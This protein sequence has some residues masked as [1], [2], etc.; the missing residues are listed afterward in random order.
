MP[1]I[2][3]EDLINRGKHLMVSISG[4]RG[5]IP[6]GLDPVNIVHF[7][8]AFASITG[9]KIVMGNDARPTGPILRHL[10]IGTLIACGKEI[11]DIGL[12][13]TPTVKAAVQIEN[14]DAGVMISASHNPPEWNAF[15]FMGKG[16]FFFNQEQSA[17]LVQ[18]VKNGANPSVDYTRMGKVLEK[19][20]VQ[21]HIKA[22]LSII[23]NVNEIRSKKYTVV[24]DAVSGAGRIA[25][26]MM[27]EELGCKV[28][29]LYCDPTPDGSFPRP[30]EPTPS[31]LKE[32]G[33][34]V[35]HNKASVGFALDPDAD[36][37]VIGS[38]A[39]GTINE[40]YTVPLAMM[41]LEKKIQSYKNPLIVLNQSTADLT[42]YLA[43]KMGAKVI[44][45]AVGEA[46]VVELMLEKNAVYGGEGNGGVILPD[47]PSFGR[48]TLTGAALILS[49]M[50][51]QNAATIDPLMKQL[52]E[53][54]MKKAKIEMDSVSPATVYSD[55]KKKF[56]DSSED[57]T[58]GLRLV[59]KDGSWIHARPSNTEPIMRII[60]QSPSASRLEEILKMIS[61]SV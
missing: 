53:L 43:N 12:A 4:I 32:F 20:G 11:I 16:G 7:S 24:V 57:T 60:A 27:L 55:I 25:L 33:D 42:E 31:A 1:Q 17:A 19:D 61:V 22:V 13:P 3:R 44:R 18:A 41:G 9:K 26:P 36:R 59:L 29:R 45:S 52:P 6:D 51:S 30:P 56:P 39:T 49:A 37:L 15:K 47:V 38:P 50:A 5:V 8:L 2:N 46:N 23:L 58:D 35:I 34:L 40:E 10:L 54:H 48:D 14:A 28:I 21:A